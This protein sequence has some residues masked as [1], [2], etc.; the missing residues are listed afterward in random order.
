[1]YKY[2]STAYKFGGFAGGLN[3][4][5]FTS[6]AFIFIDP[7]KTNL[8]FSLVITMVS[9][10]LTIRFFKDFSNAGFLSFAEGMTVGFV[11]Y[12]LQAL[13]SLLGILMILFVS[14]ELFDKIKDSKFNEFL[15][16]KEN[17]INLVGEESY[18]LAFENIKNM[19]PLDIALDSAIWIIFFGLFFTIIISI[20]L[21]KN[22]N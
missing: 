9:I 16:T 18:N 8:I 22:P 19:T 21:R 3:I 10:Y 14:P 7:T 11:S 20:I 6:L 12:M 4:I 5:A 17:T 15:T 13:I 1:M 2:F